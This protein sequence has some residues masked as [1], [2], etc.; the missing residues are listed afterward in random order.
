MSYWKQTLIGLTFVGAAFGATAQTP[1]PA[2]A[3]GA[4]QP[5]DDAGVAAR[6]ARMDQHMTAMQDLRTRM[7]GAK[8]PAQR[9]ALWAEHSR[10][11]QEGMTLMGG[12]G[13][14]GRGM[15]MGMGGM[16]MGGMG[17]RGGPGASLDAETRQLMLERRMEMMQSMMQLMMDRQAAPAARP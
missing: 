10:L 12:M 3:P 2:A 11:M 5:A 13:P 6:L 1:P 15:G 17:M 14:G 8:T 4:A 16:G 9:E 7:A